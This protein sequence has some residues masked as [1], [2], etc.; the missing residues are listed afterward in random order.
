MGLTMAE[1]KSVTRELAQKYRRGSRRKKG[2]ILDQLMQLNGWTRHHAAWVLRCWGRTVFIWRGGRLIKIV[3]GRPPARRTRRRYYDAAVY[4]ALKQIWQWYGWMCGKRLVTVLRYQLAVLVKFGELRLTPE[5]QA[6]LER[7]SAATIDRLLRADKRKLLLRGRSHTRP[8]RRLLHEIPIRTFSEWQDAQAGELGADLVGHD[9]GYGGEHAFTLVVTDRA[10]Q[11][12]E[13]RAVLNKAQKWVFAALLWIR[14]ELPFPLRALHTDCGAEFINHHLT[15][16]C[17]EQGIHFTR[18]RPQR[19][20]DN[21]FTEQKNFDVIRKHIGY[22]R[23]ESEQEVEVLNLIYDRVRLL[24]NFFYP[25]QKLVAKTRQG[26]RTRRQYDAPQTPYQRVLAAAEVSEAAKERLRQQFEG[27]NPVAL[28]REAEQLHRRL[29]RLR[30]GQDEAGPR[31]GCEPERE[32][33]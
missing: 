3:V 28:M 25:S 26:A 13:P 30:A 16:Y 24:V 21:N 29:L 7:I 31:A 11:W 23:Y 19:K 32:A 12:T 1:R 27:L 15:R 10:T 6:K 9:G 8:S 33:R 14:E 22:L 2:I 5:V 4:A 20:N 17:R 18:T